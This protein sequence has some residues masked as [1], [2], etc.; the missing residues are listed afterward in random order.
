[1]KK[2]FVAI[3]GLRR[4]VLDIYLLRCYEA[5]IKLPTFRITQSV[6]GVRNYRLTVHKVAKQQRSKSL[7]FG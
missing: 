6:R 1:M 7:S 4:G 3:S 5:Q 2:D